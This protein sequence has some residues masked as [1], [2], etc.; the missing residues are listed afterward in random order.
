MLRERIE[1][2]FKENVD[3]KNDINKR[4]QLKSMRDRDDVDILYKQ[5]TLLERENSCLKNEIKNQQYI[6]KM[7][8]NEN[9]TSQWKSVNSRNGK[10]IN[11]STEPKSSM[12]INLNNRFDTLNINENCEIELDDNTNVTPTRYIPN[13]EPKSR[14][15]Q[16]N[17]SKN[18]QLK[19]PQVAITEKY[20]NTQRE[21]P[22]KVLPGNR[23]YASTTKYGKKICVVGDSHISRI[24]KNLFNNSVRNGKAYLSSFRGANI[25]RLNH[26]ITPTLAEDRPDIVIIHVGCN[27][28]IHEN[29]DQINAA[30]VS[31]RLIEI[32]EKCKSYGVKE[33]IFSS[34]LL[35]RQ[36]KLTKIIRQV[37]DCL[38]D[39]CEKF[40]FLFVS[41]DNI[42]REH[43]WN[44]G[45]H[46]NDNGTFIFASNI[47]NFL[48]NFILN[49]NIGLTST[50][51]KDKDF[52]DCISNVSKNDSLTS[53]FEKNSETSVFETLKN[54]KNKN[55]NRITIAQLNINSR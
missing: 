34:I 54:I 45:I 27:D 14:N 1:E 10:N 24:K 2:S 52:D 43:L 17:N 28:I 51:N 3:F 22:R 25:K 15:H 41:N 37:N 31:K 5:I 21:P 8:A 49:I 44:D 4:L 6:I 30:D 46:L 32:G 29:I 26:F 11:R 23:S 40:G 48:N 13:G 20:I 12:S 18:Q 38:R 36:M 47:V 55:A 19:R 35:K 9:N 42:S 39:D 33:V 7:L 16:R 50:D 53:N